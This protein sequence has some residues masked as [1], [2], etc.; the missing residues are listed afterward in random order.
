MRP[1]RAEQVARKGR[2]L[3]LH[4]HTSRQISF[5]NTA[6]PKEQAVQLQKIA[7]GE[8]CGADGLFASVSSIAT[9]TLRSGGPTCP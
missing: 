4:A 2:K 5:K 8:C 6:V 7:F 9:L 3:D 1:A